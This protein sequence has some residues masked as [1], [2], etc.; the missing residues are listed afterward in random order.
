MFDEHAV[1]F[2]QGNKL[3]RTQNLNSEMIRADVKY[4]RLR[5]EN[6]QVYVNGYSPSWKQVCSYILCTN[7][8]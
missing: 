3:K 8:I 6:T 7:C 1:I 2:Q 4:Q 5:H